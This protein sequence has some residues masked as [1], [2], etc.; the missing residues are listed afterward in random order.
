MIVA[1]KIYG[2]ILYNKSISKSKSIFISNKY[3]YYKSINIL[4]IT[5]LIQFI[6]YIW[7][8]F[9]NHIVIQLSV[10]TIMS[11]TFCLSLLIS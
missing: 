4:T 3:I 7:N 5:I 8:C 10:Q 1:L 2:A 11:Y 6:F 9:A